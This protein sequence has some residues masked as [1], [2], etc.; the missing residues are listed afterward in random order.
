MSKCLQKILISKQVS[1]IS[2][3]GNTYKN[4]HLLNQKHNGFSCK[5]LKKELPVGQLCCQFQQSRNF[6]SEYFQELNTNIHNFV[7]TNAPTVAIK[8]F[9]IELHDM[10]GLPWWSEILLVTAGMKLVI[11]LPIGVFQ[12]HIIAKINLT[13]MQHSIICKKLESELSLMARR[14]KWSDMKKQRAFITQQK[15]IW[16]DLVVKNNCH[17]FKLVILTWAHLPPWILLSFSI[18]SLCEKDLVSPMT[19]LQLQTEGLFWNSNLIQPDPYFILPVTLFL[20][21]YLFQDLIQLSIGRK[22]T[23]FFLKVFSTIFRFSAVLFLIVGAIVPSGL[24]LYW[25]VSILC[26]IAQHLL[27]L[28]PKVRRLLRIPI[29]PLEKQNPYKHLADSFVEKYSKINSGSYRNED[30]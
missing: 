23:S 2:N 3:L 26:S 11:G 13:K 17:P 14:G 12:Q 15:M 28:S 8:N 25:S 4:S 22:P 18:R 16:S 9:L 10:S 30:N 19:Y 27:L 6:S 29:T 5:I 1:L 7:T 20:S 24:S 21:T